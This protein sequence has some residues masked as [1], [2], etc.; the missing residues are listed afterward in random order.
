MYAQ[1]SFQHTTVLCAVPARAESL[2]SKHLEDAEAVFTVNVTAGQEGNPGKR[3]G[4]GH[5]L[6]VKSFQVKPTL[7]C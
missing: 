2:S 7:S 1:C 3:G 4:S 6:P 5:L